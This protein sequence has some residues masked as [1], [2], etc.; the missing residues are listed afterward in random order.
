MGADDLLLASLGE[1]VHGA[2]ALF[3][4]QPDDLAA[5]VKPFFTQAGFAVDDD[6]LLKIIPLIRERLVT[7][8]DAIPFAGFVSDPCDG[9]AAAAAC[10][11]AHDVGARASGCDAGGPSP[12]TPPIES[13]GISLA[14]A[15][16]ASHVTRDPRPDRLAVTKALTAIDAHQR[17]QPSHRSTG[18]CN[19][20]RSSAVGATIATPAR[21]RSP[22][23]CLSQRRWLK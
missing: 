17:S 3:G 16:A 9:A 18:A 1:N 15:H 4:F 20:Q 7:L 23:P 10:L 14:W 21:C 11:L 5:R 12:Y 6:L 2:L 13:L 19:W 8:D 22:K